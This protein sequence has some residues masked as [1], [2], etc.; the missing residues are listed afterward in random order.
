[1]LVKFRAAIAELKLVFPLR[2]WMQWAS[3]VLPSA[4]NNRLAEITAH[5]GAG[6]SPDTN[7]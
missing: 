1:M 2:T 7:G 5:A 4:S 3:G 6:F